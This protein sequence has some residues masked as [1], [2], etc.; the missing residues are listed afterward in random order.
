MEGNN[1]LL[2]FYIELID[3]YTKKLKFYIELIDN[4]TKL[5]NIN[6]IDKLDYDNI[7]RLFINNVIK[8]KEFIEYLYKQK[9]N[10][11]KK[12][13]KN[14]F[15]NL[16]KNTIKSKND[17]IIIYMKKIINNYLK[18]ENTRY[19]DISYEEIYDLYIKYI[20]QPPLQSSSQT[21]PVT[22][23]S[24]SSSQSS[25]VPP[26][27]YTP[28]NITFSN[29]YSKYKNM[30]LNFIILNYDRNEYLQKHQIFI[31]DLLIIGM[32]IYIK[33]MK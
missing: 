5:K 17:I 10:S 1:K 15:K 2:K 19:E 29:L 6:Y 27:P 23:A 33:Y 20:I 18:H 24:Q 7:L 12:Y 31:Q 8:D 9:N 32:T 14:N 22:P 11:E 3:N 25:Q 26:A 13:F 28:P 21:P 4:Y 30:P 16:F